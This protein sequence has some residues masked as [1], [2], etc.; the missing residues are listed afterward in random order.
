MKISK[1]WILS[2]LLK[3]TFP[4]HKGLLITQI[5]YL[6]GFAI[7]AFIFTFFV[8]NE[9]VV[10]TTKIP[11]Y[12]GWISDKIFNINRGYYWLG[13]FLIGAIAYFILLYVDRKSKLKAKGLRITAILFNKLL[14]VFSVF[15]GL[16]LFLDIASYRVD[17][18]EPFNSIELISLGLLASHSLVYIIKNFKF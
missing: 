5:I 13:A 3:N 14:G 1:E 2:K 6:A 11:T 4:T 15:M 18:I 9:T 8:L 16:G 17:F 7:A 12:L 10:A